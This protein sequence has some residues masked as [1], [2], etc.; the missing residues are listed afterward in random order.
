[1]V[2]YNHGE[3]FQEWLFEKTTHRGCITEN[4]TQ[5]GVPLAGY[6]THGCYARCP[7]LFRLPFGSTHMH[8]WIKY[9][10][11]ITAQ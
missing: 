4:C 6:L 7:F 11:V 9:Y 8:E 10:K 5:D 1:M 3:S 2:L